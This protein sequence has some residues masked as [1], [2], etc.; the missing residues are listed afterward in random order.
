MSSR[1]TNP[2]RESAWHNL[3]VESGWCCKICGAFPE[4]GKQ[5][6]KNV[7]DDCG[8]LLNNYDPTPTA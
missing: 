4:I 8:L 7:C 2:S 5:F 6:D 3:C 1:S